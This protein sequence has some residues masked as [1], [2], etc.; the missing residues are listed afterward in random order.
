M[1]PH[2]RGESATR[3]KENQ[4][5]LRSI[6]LIPIDSL[7]A[8]DGP[9]AGPYIA[10]KPIGGI[11]CWTSGGPVPPIGIKT[12]SHLLGVPEKLAMSI[13]ENKVQAG[14]SVGS[15]AIHPR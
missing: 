15:A 8:P 5:G 6:Q 1:E 9:V 12:G 3:G 10:R 2:K 4:K 11:R 14:S 13:H 7:L